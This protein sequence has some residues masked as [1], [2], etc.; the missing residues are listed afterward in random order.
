MATATSTVRKGDQA[1]VYRLHKVATTY[2]GIQFD[3]LGDLPA[4]EREDILSK[5]ADYYFGFYIPGVLQVIRDGLPNL[6]LLDWRDQAV[7]NGN[8]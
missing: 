2:P 8:A 1:E 5:A 7:L 6:E 4:A 3:K